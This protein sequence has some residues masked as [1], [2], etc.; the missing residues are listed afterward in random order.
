LINSR[1][2]PRNRMFRGCEHDVVLKD[3]IEID[4]PPTISVKDGDGSIAIYVGHKLLSV[5]VLMHL[6]GH[7]P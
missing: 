3:V 7:A 1:Y 5:C 4:V 6:H 2:K